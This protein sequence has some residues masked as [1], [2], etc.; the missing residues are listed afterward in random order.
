MSIRILIRS[1]AQRAT[2][3]TVRHMY[4][5]DK[6]V[7]D[8]RLQVQFMG[9]Y[10]EKPGRVHSTL[11]TGTTKIVLRESASLI[12]VCLITGHWS[13]A[14]NIIFD[15]TMFTW[16]RWCNHLECLEYF[17]W[18]PRSCKR[19]GIEVPVRVFYDDFRKWNLSLQSIWLIETLCDRFSLLFVLFCL[20]YDGR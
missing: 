3:I 8:S 16:L 20:F 17:A 9:R 5:V 15:I 13:K 1:W 2:R 18:N 11:I 10:L 6:L 19:T 7:L 4:L 14:V 12:Q